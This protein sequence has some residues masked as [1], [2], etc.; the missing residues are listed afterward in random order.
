MESLRHRFRP[1]P[2]LIPSTP[3]PRRESRRGLLLA[4]AALA[5]LAVLAVLLRPTGLT[6]AA[7]APL[8]ARRELGGNES[9]PVGEDGLAALRR[10]DTVFVT[11]ASGSM[12]PFVAHW[13]AHAREHGLSPLLVAAL[14]G[15]ADSA[16]RALGLLV[17]HL[18][19]LDANVVGAGYVNTHKAAFKRMGALKVAFLRRLLGLGVAVAITD[20]DVTWLGDPRPYFASQGLGAADV[21]ASSDCINAEDDE[22]GRGGGLC[23]TI[24]NFNTGV[25]L[26]RPTPGGTLFVDAWLQ[27]LLDGARDNVTWMRDQPAFNLVAR[28]GWLA[29]GLAQYTARGSDDTRALLLVNKGATALGDRKSVV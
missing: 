19:P 8:L 16:A 9:T 14:D 17:A 1:P 26:L 25:L 27:Q 6:L 12:A 22:A 10:G 3:R 4:L 18:S 7:S 11:F 13:A 28:A 23:S 15:T 20:A 5:T 29:D 21:L 2:L 24:T